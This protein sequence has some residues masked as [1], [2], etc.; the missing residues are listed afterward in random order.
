MPHRPPR[1]ELLVLGIALTLAVA[2]CSKDQP[3]AQAPTAS[4]SPT[5][6]DVASTSPSGDGSSTP[7]SK[8]YPVS[9]LSP[10]APKALATLPFTLAERSEKP[11]ATLTVGSLTTGETGTRLTF[12]VNSTDKN[13]LGREGLGTGKPEE[14]P[15]LTDPATKTIYRV[16]TWTDNGVPWGCVC[17]GA[18]YVT[19]RT[20]QPQD[21]SYPPLPDS[22]KNVQITLP[23][24]KAPVTVEVTR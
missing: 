19:A 8:P 21:A 7:S 11:T 10:K 15:T 22:V 20:V 3:S 24:A 17:S 9:S 23:G 14:Y 6:S 4:S 12:W 2:G 13:L 1:P 18:P 5:A 16:D